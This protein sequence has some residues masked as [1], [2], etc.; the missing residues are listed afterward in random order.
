MNAMNRLFLAFCLL[1]APLSSRAQEAAPVVQIVD[2]LPTVE[3]NVPAQAPLIAFDLLVGMTPRPAWWGR[4]F[5]EDRNLRPRDFAVNVDSVGNGPVAPSAISYACA[6]QARWNEALGLY[7]VHVRVS[8]KGE[9]WPR[10]AAFRCRGELPFPFDG[11]GAGL[12]FEVVASAPSQKERRQAELVEPRP[13]VWVKSV[14]V[15]RV[16]WPRLLGGAPDANYQLDVTMAGPYEVKRE[17]TLNHVFFVDAQGKEVR[18]EAPAGWGGEGNLD[19]LTS[20]LGEPE[21]AGARLR[22]VSRRAVWDEGVAKGSPELWVKQTFG[23][24][25]RIPITLTVPVQRDGKLLEGEISP[26]DW[27]IELLTPASKP[28]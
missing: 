5:G 26:R 10:G 17:M 9:K 7:T 20:D 22:F 25:G 24:G 15:L 13:S 6:Y 23:Y 2:V 21:F 12:P 4:H 18:P 28:N 8:F 1:C 11:V 16:T 27:N 3:P 14:R 19:D